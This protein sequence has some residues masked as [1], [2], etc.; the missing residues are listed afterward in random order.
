MT[1]NTYLRNTLYHLPGLVMDLDLT[2]DQRSEIM[3][4][5]EAGHTPFDSA[6]LMIINH[7][8]L[9]WQDSIEDSQVAMMEG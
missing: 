2:E 8:S 1:A 5:R 7:P 6:T 9:G 3:S 4:H